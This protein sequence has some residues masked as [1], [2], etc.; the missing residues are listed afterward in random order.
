MPYPNVAF[1]H[2]RPLA[3][4]PCGEVRQLPVETI[5]PEDDF[6][7]PPYDW[8]ANRLGFYPLFLAVGTEAVIPMTGYNNQFSRSWRQALASPYHNQVLFRY[9][10]LPEARFSDYDAWHLILNSNYY[11]EAPPHYRLREISEYV[12]RLVLKPSWKPSDWLRAA[13][14]D[15]EVQGHVETLNLAAANL[16]WCRNKATKRVLADRGFDAEKIEVKRLPANP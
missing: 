12:G 2:A 14:R 1:Y 9:D 8:L 7:A 6:W 15:R 16:I 11:S 13:A 5:D 3:Y 4:S 10:N